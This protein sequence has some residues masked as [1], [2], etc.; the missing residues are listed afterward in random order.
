MITAI[1]NIERI[2]IMASYAD[3]KALHL[4]ARKAKDTNQIA[5]LSTI[6]GESDTLIKGSG[7]DPDKAVV[8]VVQRMVKGNDKSM[9]EIVAHSESEDA[10][11]ANPGYQMALAENE[12]LSQFLPDDLMSEAEIEAA[13]NESGI[14]NMSVIGYLKKT[15]GDKIDGKLAKSVA[16]RLLG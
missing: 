6:I 13:I 4:A 9:T 1:D 11:K 3:M 5:L 14:T 8:V 2:R 12:I 16:A 15:Y 10:A 7:M